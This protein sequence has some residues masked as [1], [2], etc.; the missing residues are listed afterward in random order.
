MNRHVKFPATIQ[1]GGRIFRDPA[2]AGQ[3]WA[4]RVAERL[5]NIASIRQGRG[6]YTDYLARVDRLRAAGFRRTRH[7]F[8][9]ILPK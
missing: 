3:A 4:Q 8:R 1:I 5:G 2:Q 9:R 7:I 6:S